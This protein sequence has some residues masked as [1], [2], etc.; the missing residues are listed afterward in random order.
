MKKY[1]GSDMFDTLCAN[2]SV[3]KERKIISTSMASTL[4]FL[5]NLMKIQARRQ[6]DIRE[7]MVLLSFLLEGS[8]YFAGQYR[9]PSNLELLENSRGKRFLVH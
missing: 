5:M 9:S 4:G 7:N 2:A 1:K 3:A 6:R 8:A